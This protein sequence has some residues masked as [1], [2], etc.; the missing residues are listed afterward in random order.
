MNEGIDLGVWEAREI[1]TAIR[2]S[3]IMAPLAVVCSGSAIGPHWVALAYEAGAVLARAAIRADA[4]RAGG[5]RLRR[6][7]AR[8]CEWEIRVLACL[9]M[10][11]AGLQVAAAFFV[12]PLEPMT[13][14]WN[15]DMSKAQIADAVAEGVRR[16]SAEA[17]PWILAVGLCGLAVALLCGP[18]DWLLLGALGA[19]LGARPGRVLLGRAGREDRRELAVR[20]RECRRRLL[21]GARWTG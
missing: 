12:V 18:T 1:R 20:Q 7:L 8:P 5:S 17:E 21:R 15:P 19:R 13:Q 10:V 11:F 9:A 3:A 14:L 16:I 2:G 6:I 4:A